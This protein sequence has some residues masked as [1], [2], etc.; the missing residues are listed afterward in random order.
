MY[1]YPTYQELAEVI[2]ERTVNARKRAY[3]DVGDVLSA[4]A[5]SL[6][7]GLLF[8]L[9]KLIRVCFRGRRVAPQRR[10]PPLRGGG[11]GWVSSGWICGENQTLPFRSVIRQSKTTVFDDG[12]AMP[13]CLS[14]DCPGD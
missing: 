14:W 1:G 8:A 13:F 10:N 9:M 6:L 11:S 7:G 2:E 12:A 5:G 3:L 4:I